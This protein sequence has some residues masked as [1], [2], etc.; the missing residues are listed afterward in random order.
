M[1]RWKISPEQILFG[2]YDI[3]KMDIGV[4]FLFF[5]E[6]IYPTTVIL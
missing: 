5:S 3:Y 2:L 6:C 1:W 4:I